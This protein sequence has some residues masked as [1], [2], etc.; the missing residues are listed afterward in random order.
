[1]KCT[2][3]SM[4]RLLLPAAV[5][6]CVLS[7]SAV[8]DDPNHDI[9]VLSNRAD[10]ISGG[11]ALVE[12]IVPPGIIQAISNGNQKIKASLNGVP[13]PDGTLALRANG[14]ILGLITGLKVGEN[15][16]KVQTPGKAM[17]IV[18]T[19][20]PIG[21][22]VFAGAQLQPWICATMVSQTVTVIG[23]PGSTPPTATATTRA[24]GL[25]SDPI[26]VQ[27]DTPPT[28]SSTLDSVD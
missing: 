16:L 25:S 4:C 13:V 5:L 12:V 14:R 18:I 20:H 15:I 17:S 10:L 2:I 27:C 6:A 8:A 3:S 19:N 22:P 1:M 11:D 24:S 23:N 28:Y 9:I 21:G 26:D 7:T